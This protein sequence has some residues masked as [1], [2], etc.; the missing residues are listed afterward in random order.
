MRVLYPPRGRLPGAQ[1]R[2]L[3]PLPTSSSKISQDAA[4]PPPGKDSIRDRDWPLQCRKDLE[5]CT[6]IL[7]KP[8]ASAP[9]LLSCP[10]SPV[11]WSCCPPPPTLPTPAPSRLPGFLLFPSGLQHR[12]PPPPAAPARL[13]GALH[14]CLIDRFC[15][16][17]SASNFLL[18]YNFKRFHEEC[19]CLM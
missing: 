16:I 14:F 8:S 9:R 13:G 15:K 2:P 1:G 11:S 6:Q 19:L 7:P 3:P 4:P 17:K 18:D 5:R 10:P 12:P